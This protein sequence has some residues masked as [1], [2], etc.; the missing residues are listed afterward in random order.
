MSDA[1]GDVELV[2]FVDAVAD[3]TARSEKADAEVARLTAL[4]TPPT[5]EPTV[6]ESVR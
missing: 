6:E 3:A 2:N 5:P 4:V 1:G